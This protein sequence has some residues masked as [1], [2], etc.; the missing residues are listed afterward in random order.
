MEKLIVTAD[1]LYLEYLQ[2]S[3]S[4]VNRGVLERADMDPL[5]GGK[6]AWWVVF[7]LL[8]IWEGHGN[9]QRDR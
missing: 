3:H 1:G 7:G 4:L 9:G 6:G 2:W 5:L 8:T